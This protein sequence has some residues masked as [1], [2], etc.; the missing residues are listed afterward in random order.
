MK[1]TRDQ[2][3]TALLEEFSLISPELRLTGDGRA[4][5][6]PGTS[7]L[8]GP[9]DMEFK[10]RARGRAAH[11]LKYLGTLEGEPDVLGYTGCNLPLRIGGTLRAPDTSEINRMLTALAVDKS[12]AGDLLNKLLGGGK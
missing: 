7:L 9:L 5:V 2:A 8:D 3:R 12:G 10:L 11:L 1:I 6:Q 4:A